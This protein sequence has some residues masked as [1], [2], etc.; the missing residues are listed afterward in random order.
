MSEKRKRYTAAEM[1]WSNMT[2]HFYRL[3]YQPIGVYRNE[4]KKETVLQFGV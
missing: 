1:Q 2:G 4:S 3:K